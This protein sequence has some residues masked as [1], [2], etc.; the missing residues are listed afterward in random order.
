[1][2]QFPLHPRLA[3]LVIAANGADDAIEMAA[4]PPDRRDITQIARRLLGTRYSR[5]IDE[6]SLRRAVLAAFPDRV[7]MRRSAKSRELLLATGTGATLAREIEHTPGEFFVAMEVRGEIVHRVVPIDREWL[8]DTRRE[9]IE[10]VDGDSVR[11][12]ERRYYMNILLHEQQVQRRALPKKRVDVERRGPASLK[13]PSGRSVTLDYRDDGSVV[14]SAKLQE[15][16]GLAETP[17][18][19]PSRTPVTFQLLAPNGRPV[20][21]TK[22][23]RSFWNGTYQEVRKELRSRYPKHPWPED[24]WT[25]VATHRTKGRR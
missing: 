20:Q 6:D 3:R 2:Q 9:T 8:T 1:M 21:V 22:D 11:V 15:L 24:P 19:G 12:M 25:A 18:V 14:A 7:A 13:L 17:R 5:T 16:F 23:L 10:E 4:D